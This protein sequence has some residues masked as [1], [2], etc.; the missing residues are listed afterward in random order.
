MR[1]EILHNQGNRDVI[2]SRNF[3]IPVAGILMII[4]VASILLN[5]PN[6]GLSVEMNDTVTNELSV[7]EWQEDF[8]VFY[9][10][11]LENYPYLELKQRTHGFVWADMYDDY[12]TRIASLTTNAEFLNL[13]LDAT[14]AL[15]NRHSHVFDPNSIKARIAGL[16]PDSFLLEIF[17]EQVAQASEDWI[18]IWN[19]VMKD[20]YQHS[21][22]VKIVYH[23]GEYHIVD[24]EPGW[25]IKYGNYSTILSVDGVPIHTA[26]AERYQRQYLDWDFE[27]NQLY[28]WSINPVIFGSDVTFMIRNTNGTEQTV[29]FETLDVYPAEANEYPDVRRPVS[30]QKWHNEKVAYVRFDTFDYTQIDPFQLQIIEFFSDINLYDDIIIDI[31][32]NNGGHYST[33]MNYIASN[34]LAQDQIIQVNMAYTNG[35]YVNQ[36][37][38]SLG[39]D[40]TTEKENFESLP[41]EVLT[42]KYTIYQNTMTINAANSGFTGSIHV[43]I[44]NQVY[45][46]SEY[47]AVLCKEYEFATLYGTPTG[48]DGMLILPIYFVL[49]NSKLVLNLAS[50]MGIHADGTANEEIRTQ[51]DVYYESDYGNFNQLIEHVRKLINT[52]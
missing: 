33:W 27:N 13:M 38:D 21:F 36:M 39:L 43:L 44:D 7:R 12:M 14:M 51:P 18:P 15:Q 3:W 48:G 50:A 16:N 29:I 11:I 20:R 9:D 30:F 5:M 1:T 8:Q 6:G 2:R 35:K 32:G 42:D 31:R 45:S 19:Q 41:T 49:P 47:F 52:A 25:E 26:V 4:L 10:L 23:N 37:R 17:N 22:E 28:A 40:A 24:G 46:A 34:L